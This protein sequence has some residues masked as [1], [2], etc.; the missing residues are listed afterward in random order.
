MIVVDLSLKSKKWLVEKNIENFIEK[1]CKQIIPLTEISKILNKNFILEVAVLLVS[2]AQIKKMNFEFRGKNKPTDVLSFANLDEK[3]IRKVGLK[4]AVG[5]SNYLHLGDIVISYEIV[6]KESLAQKKKFTHHLT[7]L[8]LHS[9]LHLIGHD[10]E[11]KKMAE[12]MEDLEIK[13][14]RK[15]KI[16]NPY[17]LTN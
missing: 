4:K 6:K 1:T 8:I 14:L 5:A 16:K 2:D 3:L 12:T 7:H 10:H 13:I 9:I 11:D 17:Q 15:I